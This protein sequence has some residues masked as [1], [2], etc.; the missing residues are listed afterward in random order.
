MAEFCATCGGAFIWAEYQYFKKNQDKYKPGG[1]YESQTYLRESYSDYLNDPQKEKEFYNTCFG[2]DYIPEVRT[3]W[4]VMLCE[5]CSRKGMLGCLIDENGYCMDPKC[6][7]HAEINEQK[8]WYEIGGDDK[9][10][11]EIKNKRWNL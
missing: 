8:G 4:D 1:E 7:Q 6:E 10:F 9:T 3:Q 5:G 2:M 11:G